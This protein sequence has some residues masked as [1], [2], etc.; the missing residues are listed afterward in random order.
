LFVLKK[1]R[2]GIIRTVFFAAH[3]ANHL[4]LFEKFMVA[5]AANI[6]RRDQNNEGLAFFIFA[7]QLRSV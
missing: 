4:V 3:D 7:R 5:F 1:V 6:E 2:I